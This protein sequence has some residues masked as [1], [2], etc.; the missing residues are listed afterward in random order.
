M[1][2][3][4]PVMKTGWMRIAASY[5]LFGA[6]DDGSMWDPKEWLKSVMAEAMESNKIWDYE[7]VD[8]E[9]GSHGIQN[10]KFTV[11]INTPEA[12]TY[13]EQFEKIQAL[14][15]EIVHDTDVNVLVITHRPS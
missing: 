13:A 9:L 3:I 12:D 6:M 8:S 14:L 2:L 7:F 4:M 1:A 10:V 5:P 15:N 11:D